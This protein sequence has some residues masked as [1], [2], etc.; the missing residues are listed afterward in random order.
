MNKTLNELRIRAKI[1]FKLCKSD[2]KNA[3]ARL[4]KCYRSDHLVGGKLQLKHCQLVLAKELGFQDWQH[5]QRVFSG[6]EHN[7]LVD[8]D[9][10]S[11]FYN[12][13][14]NAFLNQW[15]ATYNEA[16]TALNSKHYLLPYKK[17]F[18]V[19]TADYIK[20]IGIKDTTLLHEI[21]NDIFAC[22]PS[23]TWDKLALQVLQH[24]NALDRLPLT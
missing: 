24:V 14:C 19:V 7:N 4:A 8:L 20:A 15:F 17:Q 10:G 11:L 1:L 3:L 2:D 18:I 13:E 23:A 6:T 5:L 21:H 16:K 22:Y 9:M 12:S